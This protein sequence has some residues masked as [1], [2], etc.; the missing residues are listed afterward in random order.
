MDAD[1]VDSACSLNGQLA[2]FLARRDGAE[3]GFTTAILPCLR[4]AA[5]V[6]L[7]GETA[8]LGG[9]VVSQAVVILLENPSRFDPRRGAAAAFLTQVVREAARAV[10]ASYVPPGLPK[11]SCSTLATAPVALEDVDESEWVR[12]G[13]VNA[14][15]PQATEARCEAAQLIERMPPA[16]ALA[17]SRLADGGSKVTIA[18]ELRVDRFALQR[19][20]TRF[21]LETRL[22]A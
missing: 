18:A 13:Q 2:A 22:A 10:R 1:T 11:R 9:E 8:V 5:R 4:R 16:L 19:R 6:Q 7:R 17:F 14:C 21:R 3:R 20:M 12:S 15:G